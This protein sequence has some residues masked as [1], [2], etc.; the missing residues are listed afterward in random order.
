[1]RHPEDAGDR[2]VSG[3]FAFGRNRHRSQAVGIGPHRPAGKK[4]EDAL[5]SGV[6]PRLQPVELFGQVHG[7]F[8]LECARGC[9]G[10]GSWLPAADTDLVLTIGNHGL[11]RLAHHAQIAR[12]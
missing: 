2:K 6:R 4:N 12:L 10:A 1:M 5:S 11:A 8:Y 7:A 3:V 9:R